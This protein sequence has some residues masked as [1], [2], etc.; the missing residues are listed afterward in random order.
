ML[1]SV[2]QWF[3]NAIKNGAKHKNLNYEFK[4]ISF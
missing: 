2:F 3:K 4:L 1:F